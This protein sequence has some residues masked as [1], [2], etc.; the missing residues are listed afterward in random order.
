MNEELDLK[1]DKKRL[2]YLIAMP[3]IQDGVEFGEALSL[4]SDYTL[5]RWE[6][7]F[8]DWL[9]STKPEFWAEIVA[10]NGEDDIGDSYFA[11][12]PNLLSSSPVSKSLIFAWAEWI[13]ITP[14][15]LS[16]TGT[17]LFV[18]LSEYREK[19]EWNE[20]GGIS[21]YDEAVLWCSSIWPSLDWFRLSSGLSS[22]P[23]TIEQI[24]KVPDPSYSDFRA[25]VLQSFSGEAN[26][27]GTWT[28]PL[29][30]LD[31]PSPKTVTIREFYDLISA[32]G[33]D[34]LRSLYNELKKNKKHDDEGRSDSEN[35]G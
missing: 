11:Q 10:E 13:S 8:E 18:W 26:E 29:F 7:I 28:T 6:D 35:I 31:W 4:N 33:C 32:E 3:S 20:E 23:D 27:A 1:I 14:Q 2:G 5:G 24:K 30:R 25:F 16:D 19:D 15:A 34:I 17:Q 22:S 12:A 9:K 21:G